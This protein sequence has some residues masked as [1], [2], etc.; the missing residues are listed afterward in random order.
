MYKNFCEQSSV[1]KSFNICFLIWLGCQN[2]N[3]PNCNGQSKDSV[4]V[5]FISG[6]RWP[7]SRQQEVIQNCTSYQLAIRGERSENIKK[8][9]IKSCL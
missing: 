7:Y 8:Y 9:N 2:F 4:H 5:N 3:Q 1:K 6:I